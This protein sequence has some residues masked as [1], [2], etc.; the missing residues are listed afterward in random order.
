MTLRPPITD[1]TDFIRSNT[2]LL[3]PPLVPEVS[4]YLAEESLPIWQ[5]TEEELDEEGLP[6]P[7]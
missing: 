5:K 2:K 3:T 1:R 6:P 7:F 4:L